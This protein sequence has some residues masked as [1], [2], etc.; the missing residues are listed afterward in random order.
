MTIQY[1]NIVLIYIV[2]YSS[3][4]RPMFE[5][6]K[7]YSTTLKYQFVKLKNV[8]SGWCSVLIVWRSF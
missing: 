1:S 6:M 8:N 4:W 5:M 3:K 2:Q 7:Y